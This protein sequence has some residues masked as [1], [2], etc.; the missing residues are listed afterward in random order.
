MR[1]FLME[2]SKEYC[3]Y[4]PPDGET[5]DI[6]AEK[7]WTQYVQTQS[8]GIAERAWRK[9]QMFEKELAQ[10]AA[11]T[12]AGVSQKGISGL[13]AEDTYV[14]IRPLAKVR[15]T[16]R[17]G[18]VT[19][20]IERVGE[21]VSIIAVWKGAERLTG[22]TRIR[23]VILESN[24]VVSAWAGQV[25]LRIDRTDQDS[26]ALLTETV[27]FEGGDYW[28]EGGT[29]DQRQKLG[30]TDIRLVSGILANIQRDFS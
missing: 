12:L 8:E 30:E 23:C 18:G 4:L 21:A 28:K 10:L 24:P 6:L 15:L 26:T 14:D 16:E 25:R 27:V 3:Y 2:I 7:S 1:G 9:Y 13:V 17:M 29:D 11:K 5:F 20:V 19:R 22:D